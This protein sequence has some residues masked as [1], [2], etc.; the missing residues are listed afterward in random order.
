MI[1]W[2]SIVIVLVVAGV[3][4]LLRC[5]PFLIFRSGNIPPVLVYLGKV[6]PVAAMGMLVVYCLKDTGF[7]TTSEWLPSL[8]AVAGIIAA[9]LFK[10]NILI[11][12]VVGMVLYLP[13]ANLM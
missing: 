1:R 10:K 6:L 7:S 11:S 12:V 3:T 13:L 5:L 9:Q 4:L 8:I 2:Y